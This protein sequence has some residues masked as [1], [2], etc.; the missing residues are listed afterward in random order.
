MVSFDKSCVPLEL[1]AWNMLEDIIFNISEENITAKVNVKDLP[2]GN[3]SVK[4][5]VEFSKEK[6]KLMKD[7]YVTVFVQ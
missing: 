2:A 1:H 5:E 6:L 3:N 4:V 7:A